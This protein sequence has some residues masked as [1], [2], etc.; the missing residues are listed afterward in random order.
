MRLDHYSVRRD[1]MS[2]PAA[3]PTRAEAVER[4]RAAVA[5]V[6]DVLELAADVC[7]APMAARS[8]PTCRS[9]SPCAAWCRPRT[10]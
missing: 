7:Q 5:D 10:T 8:R 6:P 4:Y 2:S 1:E 3:V 9:R